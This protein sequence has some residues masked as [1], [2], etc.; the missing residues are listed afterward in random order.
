KG[1]R[2]E[3]LAKAL[4]FFLPR[5]LDE[6]IRELNTL[7]ESEIN[8]MQY[9]GPLRSYPPRHIAFAEHEDLNWFAGGGYAWDVVRRD[10]GVRKQVNTWLSEPDRLQTPYE[11]LI[12]DLVGLDQI[13]NP[14]LDGLE[15]LNEDQCQRLYRN[16]LRFR[17][18][19]EVTNKKAFNH[20]NILFSVVKKISLLTQKAIIRCL[21]HLK[22]MS[23]PFIIPK[24]TFP[25]ETQGQTQKPCLRSSLPDHIVIDSRKSIRAPAKTERC[26][27]ANCL[28]MGMALPTCLFSVG[29]TF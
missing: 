9:L 29:P 5:T 7:I 27:F 13:E 17:K 3:D 6:L 14:L 2:R 15:R 1:Y 4:R 21:I 12:R 28:C 20:C 25:G 26:L 23:I 8:R 22:Y 24:K 10:A 18:G 11:I 19:L 16:R